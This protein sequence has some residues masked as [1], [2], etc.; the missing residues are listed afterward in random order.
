MTA[1]ATTRNMTAFEYGMRKNALYGKNAKL[2]RAYE[3]M[4]AERG[5]SWNDA[6]LMEARRAW[7]AVDI[8]LYEL[9]IA[10][11]GHSAEDGGYYGSDRYFDDGYE[12]GYQP[13]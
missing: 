3:A 5:F 6:E 13:R 8:E 1:T 12:A 10:F 11:F 9:D 7:L 2:R 4:E